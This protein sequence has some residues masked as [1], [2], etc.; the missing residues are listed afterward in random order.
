MKTQSF[1]RVL[2]NQRQKKVKKMGKPVPY[3]GP[4]YFFYHVTPIGAEN[5]NDVFATIMTSLQD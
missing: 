3:W 4:V 1:I 2:L 5:A